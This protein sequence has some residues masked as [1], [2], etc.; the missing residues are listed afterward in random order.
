MQASL[1]SM[2]MSVA[3]YRNSTART[4]PDTE[5]PYEP[6]WEFIPDRSLDFDLDVRPS[7]VS[8]YGKFYEGHSCERKNGF[9]LPYD[10]NFIHHLSGD[11]QNY[12]MREN[13]RAYLAE[14]HTW[15]W[16]ELA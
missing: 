12:R 13:V 16:K 4:L 2:A 15:E 8:T 10:V 6:H 3:V 9:P 11:P 5:P 7:E 1:L 14:M